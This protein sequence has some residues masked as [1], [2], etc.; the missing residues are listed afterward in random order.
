MSASSPWQ[1][2][3]WIEA[4]CCLQ[5]TQALAHFLW[6]G[7]AVAIVYVVAARCLSRA[8]A[9]ARYL[10]GVAARGDGVMR[11][12]DVPDARPISEADGGY[13]RASRRRSQTRGGTFHSGRVA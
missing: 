6:Q 2:F 9:N 7:C 3:G 5:L 1:A 10:A 13:V 11:S 8:S 4:V 12:G